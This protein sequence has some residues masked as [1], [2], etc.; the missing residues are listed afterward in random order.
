MF[1]IFLSLSLV[2]N[3]FHIS[4]VISLLLLFMRFHFQHVQIW[5]I[6]MNVD[7]IT[8][9]HA[10]VC[11]CVCVYQASTV[12]V[13]HVLTYSSG[14]VTL[15]AA[16]EDSAAC[17]TLSSALVETLLPYLYIYLYFTVFNTYLKVFMGMTLYVVMS[18]SDMCLGFC[19]CVCVCISVMCV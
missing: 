13:K 3:N 1:I 6:R 19:A 5:P 11:V 10:F 2:N 18:M 4:K 7:D 16:A 17:H 14:H 9:K 12:Y 15:V 8:C